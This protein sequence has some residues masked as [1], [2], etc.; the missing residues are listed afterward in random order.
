VKTLFGGFRRCRRG[1]DFRGFM[2]PL[3]LSGPSCCHNRRRQVR[4]QGTRGPT[5]CVLRHRLRNSAKHL[6]IEVCYIAESGRARR[7]SLRS[8]LKFKGKR[9]TLSL[10]R[11]TR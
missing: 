6:P 1:D 3:R 10:T 8:V 4:L 9:D 2:L 5:L 7:C 11:K